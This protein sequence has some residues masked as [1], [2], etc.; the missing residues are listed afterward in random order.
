[1]L[2]NI[3]SDSTSLQL[4]LN[5]LK[6]IFDNLICEGGT[7]EEVKAIYLQIKEL[8]CQTKV[9]RSDRKDINEWASGVRERKNM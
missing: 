2:E 5:E 9:P 6:A 7:F 4:H 1:M 3:N 8:E